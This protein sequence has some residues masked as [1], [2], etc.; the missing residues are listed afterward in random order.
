MPTLPPPAIKYSLTTHVSRD[1]GLFAH[2]N[3]HV[4]S[5]HIR[6]RKG[7]KV[8]SEEQTRPV[9]KWGRE[10]RGLLT[11]NTVNNQIIIVRKA[12]VLIVSSDHTKGNNNNH[13]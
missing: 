9:P 5:F 12:V 1:F 6:G 3:F 7:Q 13:E 2:F 11:H 10:P 8:T 4:T